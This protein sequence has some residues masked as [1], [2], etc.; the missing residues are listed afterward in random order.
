MLSAKDK[1]LIKKA[2]ER[3]HTG[4]HPFSCNA[5][6]IHKY[7][8]DKR[9]GRKLREKYASFYDQYRT[10]WDDLRAVTSKDGEMGRRQTLQRELMLDLFMHLE[11]KV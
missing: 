4:Q 1:A 10:L 8:E 7:A 11:G 6:S 3:V 9:R 5:L 2:I